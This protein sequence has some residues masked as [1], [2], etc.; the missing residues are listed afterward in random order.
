MAE[1]ALGD[2][3]T[4]AF[5]ARQANFPPLVEFIYPRRTLPVRSTG[6]DC[7]LNCAHCSGRY[8]KGML[9]LTEALK[10]REGPETSYLVSGGSD[11][12]GRVPH[13]ERLAEI[14]E[15]SQ[16]GPLNLH[17]GLV[18]EEEARTLAEI[19]RVVSFDFV[20]DEGTIQNV[21]GLEAKGD[22]Y[23]RSYRWLRRFTR[24]VPHICIGLDG[25]CI[26]GEYRA[27]EALREEGAEAISFIVFIPT[28]GTPLEGCL[29]PPVTEAARILAA[30]RLMFP[31]TP[32]FLGCM[33]PGGGYR[34][35][36]DSLALRGGIN[37]IVHPAPPAGQMALELGL[38]IRHG[39]ECC[40][41]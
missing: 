30:A 3:L 25:G 17:T 40:S 16:K 29:P 9:P 13:L 36:L 5:A 14:R 32:L 37:K 4:R 1:K 35:N 27:L 12:E 19:A 41:L 24:V 38:I 23:I 21:Y 31:A 26:K 33:R 7:P 28:P 10:R 2:L 11:L 8:L 6:G 34:R 22:D 15:L 39:E 20:V 18:G